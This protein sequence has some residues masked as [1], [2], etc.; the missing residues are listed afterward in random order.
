MHV[1]VNGRAWS[2]KN[3]DLVALVALVLAAA[4]AGCGQD[5]VMN[6]IPPT[7][8]PP[9]YPLLVNPYSV[10]DALT[11]AYQRR[12]TTE[13]KAL[14]D[15]SYQ[16]RSI[17]GTDPSPTF[18]MFT[19]SDEVRH[20]ATL[21]HTSLL[22]LSLIEANGLVR[23]HDVTDPP[24]WTTIRNPYRSLSI[25]DSLKTRGVDFTTEMNEFKFIPHAPDPTSVTDTT[26]KIVEWT[27]V[28]S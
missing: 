4:L 21:A 20:V 8:K 12:D 1:H 15:D 14:Y 22:H 16:G 5:K 26:W 6:A 27:E 28:R 24:G 2:R 13:I 25:S 23:I 19:K 17:D 3:S 9:L 11:T 10:L 18:L 7:P